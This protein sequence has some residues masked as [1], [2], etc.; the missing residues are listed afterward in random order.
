MLLEIIKNVP[1][2]DMVVQQVLRTSFQSM[3]A[4][5][6]ILDAFDGKAL[7]LQLQTV[8]VFTITNT[9]TQTGYK[10]DKAEDWR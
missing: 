2:V 9:E 7:N 6:M 3:Q 1:E 5:T 4:A 10:Y 8:M